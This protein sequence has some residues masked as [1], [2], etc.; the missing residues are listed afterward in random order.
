MNANFS[1]M[2]DYEETGALR[3]RA[4]LSS[5]ELRALRRLN[6]V[7]TSR[8]G[9]RTL[10]S[11]PWCRALAARIKSRTPQ[12]SLLRAVQ[13]TMFEKSAAS[14]WL[15]APHQDLSLPINADSS[16]GRTTSDGVR[17]AR[18]NAQTLAMCIALRLHLDDCDRNDGALRMISGSH[19]NGI[20]T[21]DEISE[22]VRAKDVDLQIANSGDA[23]MMS[24]LLIHASSKTTGNSRRRVLHFLFVPSSA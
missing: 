17:I 21:Q 8:A 14:N 9:N 15:V 22:S 3:I 18:A 1:I 7:A 13:C 24:P 19:R 23:W 5:S 12:L 6:C 4:L 11:Q 10:L 20:I 2:K 16:A